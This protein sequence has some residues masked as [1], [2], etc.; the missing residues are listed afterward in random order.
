MQKSAFLNSALSLA[1]LVN[2]DCPTVISSISDE[3]GNCMGGSV[4][5]RGEAF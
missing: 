3:N 2:P 5:F 4:G 1:K